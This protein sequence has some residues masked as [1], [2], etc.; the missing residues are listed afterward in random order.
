MKKRIIF[1]Y[2]I[3]HHLNYIQIEEKLKEAFEKNKDSEGVI[4]KIEIEDFEENNKNNK[5]FKPYEKELKE[6]MF[7]GKNGINSNIFYEV[8]KDWFKNYYLKIYK[9][10]IKN[11]TAQ[12]ILLFKNKQE[13]YDF[14]KKNEAT[15]LGFLDK[16]FKIII[17]KNRNNILHIEGEK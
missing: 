5:I 1:E 11:P 16:E 2:V 3:C 7:F 6:G 9:R 13:V 14:F 15:L 8:R 17:K 10:I 4:T 12:G